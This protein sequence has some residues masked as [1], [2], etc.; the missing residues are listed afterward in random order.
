MNWVGGSR[1]RIILKQERRK[2]KEFFEKKKL[3]SKMKL[4]E[5]SSPKSSTASLDL[6]N[7]Y[8]VNQISTKKDSTN[9]G[10]KPVHIDITEDA[11]RPV[12]RHNIELPMSP[13][14]TQRMSKLDDIQNRLQKQV[15]DSRRQH[16][17]EK[18]KYKH[19]LSQVTELRHADCSME[20]GDN[21]ARTCSACPLSSASFWP[22]NCTPLSEKHYNT[23]L[24]GNMW[25]RTYEEELQNQ[26]GN[27]CDQDPWITKPPGQCTFRKSETVPQELFRLLH[28]LDYMNSG[29]NNPAIMTSNQP[30]SSEG[31]KEPLFD[32]VK[33]TAELKTP[34]DGSACSFLALF[35]DESKP[36]HNNP[37]TKYFNPY[38]P[39][40][41]TAI[42]FIKPDNRNQMTNISYLYDTREAYPTI[43]VK[44]SCVDR[45]L[46]GVFT[47]PEQ[48][49]LKSNNVS[50]A[51]Y[52]E[53]SGLCKTH[54][55]DC[56][57]GQH[58]YFIPAEK[59]ETLANLERIDPFAYHHDQQINLQENVQNYSRR[60]R[61]KIKVQERESLTR[62]LFAS[63]SDDETLKE[64]VWRQNQLFGFEEF[65]AAQKEESKFGASSNLHEME[66]DVESSLSS[67]SLSYSPRQTESCLSSSLDTLEEE[68]THGKKVY[69]KEQPLSTDD[70]NLVSAASARTESPTTSH[71]RTAPLQPSSILTREA[72][73]LQENIS[74]LCARE[75]ESQAHPA[76]PEG[77]SLH[78]ALRR[79]LVPRSATCD[80]WSQTE[81][82][83][84]QVRKVDVAT[85]C[86]PAQ[87]C[88][89]GGSLL[90][91][92]SPGR[93]PPPGAAG[94]H[95]T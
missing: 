61:K 19:N 34:Q 89:C 42:S 63:L 52:K 28:R 68:D 12:R 85:Q 32:I 48:V 43:S 49:L 81:G 21:T 46:E 44:N 35:E 20:H 57:E 76:P 87:V 29:R 47:A 38:V 7:L 58:Y 36:I 37:S 31:I 26:P 27:S 62:E 78:Q 93:A 77:S 83:V 80:A 5:V 23:N 51:S 53:T 64:S 69:L 17:T 59:K 14:R 1:S 90:S 74:I 95:R 75:E 66:K 18:V 92:R 88:G 65:T 33:E 22:S 9:K 91:A 8:V 70:A 6:L 73:D 82:S 11:K 39:Q 4:L 94:G 25:E 72:A 84:A 15:L 2:Q 24:M 40:S 13:L 86:E 41:N 67:Q 30:E 50:S 55:Q 45:H 60:T 56:L 10:R 54:L 71:T 3:K 79:E 16:L